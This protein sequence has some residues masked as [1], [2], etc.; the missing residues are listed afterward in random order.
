M[1]LNNTLVKEYN[2]F[3][4]FGSVY[5]ATI[6]YRVTIVEFEKFSSFISIVEINLN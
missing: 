1:I 5:N 4:N 2:Y 3:F 6:K